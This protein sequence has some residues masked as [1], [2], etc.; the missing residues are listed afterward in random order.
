MKKRIV[1]TGIG[2]VSSIGIGVEEFW[3]NLIEGKSGISKVESFDTSKHI[4]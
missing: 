2:V 4:T 3:K 1:V